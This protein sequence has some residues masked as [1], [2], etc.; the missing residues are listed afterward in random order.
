MPVTNFIFGILFGL[1]IFNL[2]VH[3]QVA[4]RSRWHK[5]EKTFSAV[6][7]SAFMYILFTLIEYKTPSAE[8]Y[9]ILIRIQYIFVSTFFMGLFFFIHFYLEEK[10]YKFIYIYTAL[11]IIYLFIRIFAPNT[12]IYSEVYGMELVTLNWGDKIYMISGK[13]SYLIYIYPVLAIFIPVPYLII[14]AV[15]NFKNTNRRK[16]LFI[17]ASSLAVIF[18]AVHDLYLMIFSVNSLYLAEA[19]F[20]V[21]LLTLS[22]GLTDQLIVLSKTKTQLVKSVEEKE[23]LLRE[24]HHRVKNNLSILISLI[25]LQKDKTESSETRGH[26][27][28]TINRLYSIARVHQMLYSSGNFTRIDLKEYLKEISNQI[29]MSFNR[30]NVK[31]SVNSKNKII[32]L[33]II[34]AIPLGLII[35]EIITN[36]FKHA[37]CDQGKGE[38]NIILKKSGPNINLTISDTVKGFI[39]KGP[40]DKQGLGHQLIELLS[41]QVGAELELNSEAGAEYIITLPVSE[42][43]KPGDS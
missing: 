1:M 29:Q 39:E 42:E 14:I 13:I 28:T 12:G 17:L 10:P 33:N 2:F 20:A 22:L 19:S 5:T 23:I 35:N 41:K 9:L 34:K 6:L 18:G 7:V 16:S 36:S 32:D 21:M 3:I 11:F 38:I 43:A 25:N 15:K 27:I 8:T 26:L 24:I 37:F 30:N 31:I 4:I 40:D